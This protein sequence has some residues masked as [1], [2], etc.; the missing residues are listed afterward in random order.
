MEEVKQKFIVKC[1]V[2]IQRFSGGWGGSWNLVKVADT[3]QF[4]ESVT[5]QKADNSQ[6]DN[7]VRLVL[8]GGVVETTSFENLGRLVACGAISQV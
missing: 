6:N 7:T 1:P 8:P 3:G 2:T 4:I 5:F